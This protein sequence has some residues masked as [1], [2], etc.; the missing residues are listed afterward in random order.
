M[1]RV[2]SNSPQ[3][4]PSQHNYSHTQTKTTHVSVAAD[5]VR[6]YTNNYDIKETTNNVVAPPVTDFS[7]KGPYQPER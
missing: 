3:K 7:F 1:E 5:P 6:N 2:A 4:A